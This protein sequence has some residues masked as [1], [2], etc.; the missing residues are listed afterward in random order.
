ML[1]VK[2]KCQNQNSVL[3][4]LK[5]ILVDHF[6]KVKTALEENKENYLIK[7]WNN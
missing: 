5:M 7:Y 1:L 4:N 6:K 2:C 3:Y